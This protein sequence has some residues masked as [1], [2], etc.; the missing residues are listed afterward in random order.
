MK[1]TVTTAQRASV[2]FAVSGAVIRML[3]A[4]QVYAL[5]ASISLLRAFR[6]WEQRSISII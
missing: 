1:I 2:R 4:K 6:A 5:P 3:T